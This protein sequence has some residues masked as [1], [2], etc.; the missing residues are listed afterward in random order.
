[1][2]RSL[3]VCH[4]VKGSVVLMAVLS[5]WCK[6]GFYWE[7]ELQLRKIHSSRWPVSKS[8]VEFSRLMI[9]MRRPSS[10]CVV[11]PLGRGLWR[12]WTERGLKNKLIVSVCHSLCFSSCLEFLLWLSSVMESDLRILRKKQTLSSPSYFKSWWFCFGFFFFMFTVQI[13]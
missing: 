2:K 13:L 9:D 8:L 3:S 7:E 6:L 5:T 10:V 12:K 1:M 4:I 11:P